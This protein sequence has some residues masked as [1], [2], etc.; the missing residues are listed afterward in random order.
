M[1]QS[2]MRL[3][4]DR[5]NPVSL[6]FIVWLLII[7]HI[8]I[9]DLS[10]QNPD[11][12]KLEKL[13]ELGDVE[14]FGQR[15]PS[16]YNNLARK[17]TVITRDEI[18]A[19]PAST[20]QDL[21]EYAA[22]VDI[23]QR[24]VHGVQADIQIRGGSFD[25]VMV[26]LNGINISDPQTGHFNLDLPVELSSIERIEILHGTGARVYGAN[27]YKGV[28]NIITRKDTDMI[29]AGIKY[30]Q[31]S[32][33]QTNISGGIK[34]GNWF[35]SLGFSRNSSSGYTQNTDYDM[36]QVFYQGG[37]TYKSGVLSWQGG[38]GNKA[39]GANDFYSPMYP[40]QYEETSSGFT[41]L[42]FTRRGKLNYSFAGYWR[43]HNDHFLLKRGDPSFYEN[44]HKTDVFGLKGNADFSTVLGKTALG[45]EIRD[46]MILSNRLGDFLNSPVEIKGEDSVL[47]TKSFN[48]ATFSYFL[49]HIYTAGKF[50]FTG[51]ILLDISNNFSG[52]TGF[53]PGIDISYKILKNNGRLFLSVNRSL[54]RPTFTDMFYADPSNEG[55]RDLEPEV[56]Q[57]AEFGSD[58]KAGNYSANITLFSEHG[59]KVIDWIW[60]DDRNLYK[61][62][63]IAGINTNG[64]ELSADYTISRTGKNFE[65]RKVGTS[66]SA[67][68][69]TKVTGEFVSKYSLDFLKYKFNFHAD[70]NFTRTISANMQVS[71]FSRNGTYL[72]YDNSIGTTSEVAYEPYWLTDMRLSYSNRGL[73]VN[74]EAT[75]LFNSRYTDVGNL[76]Q[77]GRWLTAGIQFTLSGSQ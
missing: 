71:Y 17:I 62:M 16:V 24:N 26:L 75:N 74:V 12:L 67:I 34:S 44:F 70:F 55:T 38:T 19:S 73:R 41:S 40:E 54:R 27:A 30:G 42:A 49:E 77:A 59:K 53:Y 48:R 31:H 10:A 37:L 4:P 11:T 13:V 18:V 14:V 25:Q 6:Q 8:Y 76:I 52:K 47:F 22:G 46:E 32:L 35:N 60:Q 64:F 1:I 45:F 2:Q 20:I 56:L 3:S 72:D 69:L 21:L 33:L 58:F 36:N 5:L 15:I 66:I 23:R 28:I 7:F 65:F 57:A 43:R 39:F 63:N 29:S 9:S 50:S 51:G 68:T 61:A